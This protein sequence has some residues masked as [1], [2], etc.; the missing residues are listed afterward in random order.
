MEKGLNIDIK[1][2]FL[3]FQQGYSQKDIAG[4]DDFIDDVFAKGEEISFVG[5]GINDWALGSGEVKQL[6]KAHWTNKY[7][8]LS[9]LAF[10]LDNSSYVINGNT[11][12]VALTGKSS[13]IL[14][15]NELCEN[16]IKEIENTLKNSNI[17][18][19]TL[20]ELNLKLSRT[21]YE[22][23]YGSSFEWNFRT[24]AF[25]VEKENRWYIKHI[26]FSFGA[27]NYW[28]NR[29]IDETFD[30]K[31]IEIPVSNQIG[32]DTEDIRNLLNKFQQGYIK[33]DLSL[34]N[35]FSEDVFTN[36]ES[37]SIFGTDE[38]ENFYGKNAG[39]NLAKGDW[40][41]W[42]DFDLNTKNTYI[43]VEG[44]MA[45][46]ASKAIL[47]KTICKYD[48]KGVQGRILYGILPQDK[49]PKEK[50]LDALWR[51]S[52]RLYEAE[53]GD[54]FII[55]MKVSG[56]LIKINEEWKIEH[57]H[58]SENIDDMPEERIL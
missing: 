44:S 30:K 56:I 11:A 19:T 15:D 46:F 42:G 54:I 49:T 35:T 53:K 9:D 34:L 14:N 55:P 50:L 26:N 12:L 58:F 47:R 36:N 28:E 33:R 23:H 52:R 38:G 25:L 27:G 29:F 7:K 4:I 13:M 45:W 18:K 41:Y 24:T 21:L 22:I 5:T 51:S 17:D 39:F 16:R 40:Q 57:M 32:K 8:Y 31:H 37:M 43:S 48:F 6:I 2:L 10:D 1:G 20:M 3:R